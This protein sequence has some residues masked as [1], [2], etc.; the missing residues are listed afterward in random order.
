MCAEFDSV[1][2]VNRLVEVE[3]AHKPVDVAL[4][5]RESN[6]LGEGFD[7]GFTGAVTNGVSSSEVN[8]AKGLVK[9]R[10]SVSRDRADID[11]TERHLVIN[12]NAFV[13][14]AVNGVKVT[15][16]TEVETIFRDIR[17]TRNDRKR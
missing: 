5:A 11:V 8:I 15:V 16:M 14:T 10:I 7:L 3:A 12:G 9:V 1:L 4:G 6:F 17:L 13:F 2:V